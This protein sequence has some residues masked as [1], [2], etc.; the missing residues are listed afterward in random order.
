MQIKEVCRDSEANRK[1]KSADVATNSHLDAHACRIC[2]RSETSQDSQMTKHDD[3][4]ITS[5]KSKS[6]AKRKIPLQS[7]FITAKPH[8]HKR[9][10]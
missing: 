7:A 6:L 2:G 9:Y 5:N 10:R 8:S 4:Q 3:R 1:G